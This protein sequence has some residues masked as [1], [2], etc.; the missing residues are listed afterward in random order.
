MKGIILA[1]GLG[2]R[3]RPFTKYTTKHLLPVYDLPMIVF[4]I[5]T[6]VGLG[7]TEILIVA[8]GEHLGQ[9][10]DFLGDGS[11]H[12]AQFTFRCQ[13]EPRGIAHALCLAEGFAAGAPVVLHLADN[14]FER[15]DALKCGFEDWAGPPIFNGA[16]VFLKRVEDP[17]RFGV[18]EI[19]GKELRRIVEKPREFISP[20]AVTGL[21]LLDADCFSIARGLK[22]S[23]RGEVEITDLL[24]VY[25]E[26]DALRW[27]ELDGFWSD[28]GT[29]QSL[30]RAAAWAR[31]KVLG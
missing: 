18:A 25:A 26:R 15:T 24:N 19:V 16:H 22:P 10:L 2:T 11:E 6:L 20:Y 12:G 28:A 23:P 21:Y 17:E 7:V 27:T 13:T 8:G 5:R 31:S 30:W 4:P 29:V 14:V 9:L 3:L 1:G